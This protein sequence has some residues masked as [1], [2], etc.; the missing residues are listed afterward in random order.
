[1]SLEIDVRFPSSF[2]YAPKECKAVAEPFFNCFTTKA[3]KVVPEDADAGR[4][5]MLK[6]L[7]ELRAYSDCLEAFEKKHPPKRLRVSKSEIHTTLAFPA[8]VHDS[9]IR[10]LHIIPGARRVSKQIIGLPTAAE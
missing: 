4:R 1:M 3:V 5:G 6:C 7:L 9:Q 8:T 10:N 2:P